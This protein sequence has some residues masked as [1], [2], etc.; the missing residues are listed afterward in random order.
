[1]SAGTGT[2]TAMTVGAATI[3]AAIAF[4][5]CSPGTD[6][7]DRPHL[8]QTSSPPGPAAGSADPATAPT[9]GSAAVAAAVHYELVHCSWDWRMSF[10]DHLA[11]ET[12]L[13]TP[14]FGSRLRSQADPLSWRREVIAQQQR[15]T[16]TVLDARLALD[17]PNTP[18]SAFVRLIVLMHIE[19]SRGSFDTGELTATCLVRRIG[20]RWLV[21][22]PFQGG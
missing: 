9:G 11:A 8:K 10:A 16:C 20:G 1:M 22:G 6:P 4:S 3:A 5:A 2:I 19:S 13:A 12:A 15:V 18:S 14:A 17:A 21:D 7:V